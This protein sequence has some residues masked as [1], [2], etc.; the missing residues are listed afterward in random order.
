VS[1]EGFE[2]VVGDLVGN[3][4]ITHYLVIIEVMTESGLDLRV[5][6]SDNLT[7]WNAMGMLRVAADMISSY[8]SDV[9]PTEDGE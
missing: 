2:G 5:A 1:D 4:L 3:D 7:T 8:P 6:S 9:Q